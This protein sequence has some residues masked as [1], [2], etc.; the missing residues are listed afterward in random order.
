MAKLLY[1][2]LG[3]ILGALAG[4]IAS[5]LFEKV[6][7]AISDE[8]PADPDD[9]DAGWGEVLVSAAVSGAIFT[10]V[11]ALVQRGGAKGFE[12]ATGVWPGDK[13]G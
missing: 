4:V 7:E 3:L 6:W 11:R 8:D 13:Q 10:A 5:K 9:R 2:P 1:K 12:R